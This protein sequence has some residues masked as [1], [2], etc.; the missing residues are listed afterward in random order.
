MR[1]GAGAVERSGGGDAK[2]GQASE[3]G[4]DQLRMTFNFGVF[5]TILFIFSS[6]P[7]P[8]QRRAAARRRRRR[9]AVAQRG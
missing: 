3:S 1:Q 2:G 5:S 8:V 9:R 6:H 4:L 7:S